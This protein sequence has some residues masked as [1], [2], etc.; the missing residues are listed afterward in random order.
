MIDVAL[1]RPGTR[2]KMTDG[3]TGLIRGSYMTEGGIAF[4]VKTNMQSV[5]D[6]NVLLADIA[7]IVE[8]T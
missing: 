7:E 6:R 2:V 3:E 4:T 1:L 5:C 8:E